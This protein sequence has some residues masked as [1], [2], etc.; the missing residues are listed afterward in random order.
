MYRQVHRR[1]RLL[2]QLFHSNNKRYEWLKEK[3]G[4]QDYDLTESYPYLRQTKYEK[5]L[6]EVKEKSD[7]ARNAKLDRIKAHFEEEKK[8]FFQEKERLLIEIEKEVKDL[9]FENLNV[10]NQSQK[11]V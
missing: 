7:E 2:A 6:E 11:S 10:F 5:F 9:G 1:D 8:Q 3:L 4:L